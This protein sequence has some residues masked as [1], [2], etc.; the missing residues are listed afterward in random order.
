MCVGVFSLEQASGGVLTFIKPAV[1][2]K[3]LAAIAIPA[4]HNCSIHKMGEG[5]GVKGGQVFQLVLQ[6]PDTS[7]LIS[8]FSQFHFSP[9][10]TL[11]HSNENATPKTTQLK[12][13]YMKE[14]DEKLSYG[15]AAGF[16]KQ[17]PKGENLPN[18]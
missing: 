11:I 13:I 1:K 18:P 4:R 17:Q 8:R 9:R 12:T 6:C 10:T 14:M 2:Q 7:G 3:N 16:S 15:V 5:W